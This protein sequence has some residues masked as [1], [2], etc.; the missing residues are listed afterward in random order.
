MTTIHN[1]LPDPTRTDADTVLIVETPAS[2]DEVFGQ[3]EQ[4]PWPEGLLSFSTFAATDGETMLAY[5]QWAAGAA[6]HQFLSELTG[7]EPVEYRLYRS[8][9]R[10]NPPPPGCIVVVKVEFDGPDEQRQRRWVDTVFEALEGETEP[11]PGGISGHF[12]V[13][14]DGTR[15][16]NYAEWTDEQAHRDAL[17]SSRQGTVGSSPGWQRVR[18]FPGVRGSGFRR[19][20]PMRS[21]SAPRPTA[22]SEQDDVSDSPT[23][24]VAE[25]IRTYVETNGESHL[26]QGWPTLL[27]TTRGR[28][29]GKL[30]RTALIYAQ[31]GDRYLLVASNAG[32]PHH[33]A[34]Y[35]NLAA[36]PE[37]TVQVRSETF[38][39][40]ARTATEE[41]K[42]LLWERTTAVFPLYDTYQ[43][44]ASRDIPLVIVERHAGK[45]PSNP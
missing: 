5:T 24:W 16:L 36:H 22:L 31:D 18:D 12:H 41:E 40:R 44:K 11:H 45:E 42:R 35:L 8:Q 19:Y 21:L 14:T 30:R 6:G 3:L 27:L 38:P 43:A 37:V 1:T 13:S 29:S 15:V 9:T 4:K 7:G 26:Y 25:H 33:P 39:A 20:H 10:E 28:K 23:D 34:W 17:E 32:A 2:M